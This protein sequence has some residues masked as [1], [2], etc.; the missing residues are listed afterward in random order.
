[1]DVVALG[2]IAAITSTEIL[3]PDISTAQFLHL[4]MQQRWQ[5]TFL[6]FFFCFLFF[7]PIFPA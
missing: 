4:R 2:I 6:P 7:L 5:R 1:M 3:P